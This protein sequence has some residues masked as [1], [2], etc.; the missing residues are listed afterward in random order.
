MFQLQLRINGYW[1]NSVYH[2]MEENKITNIMNRLVRSYPEID[3]RII[4]VS[5]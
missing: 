4:P 1:T 5:N 2:P 3:Y